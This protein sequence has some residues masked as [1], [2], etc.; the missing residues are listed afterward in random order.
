VSPSRSISS[1]SV[2]SAAVVGNAGPLA[3]FQHCAS[4]RIPHDLAP[5]E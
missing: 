1:H 2:L 3:L 5:P 4:V